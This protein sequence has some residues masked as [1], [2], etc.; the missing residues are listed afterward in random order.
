MS[1]G[2]GN[3]QGSFPWHSDS[4]PSWPLRTHSPSAH[5]LALGPLYPLAHPALTDPSQIQI[6][7]YRATASLAHLSELSDLFLQSPIGTNVR[8]ASAHS[9]GQHLFCRIPRGHPGH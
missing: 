2:L 1:E 4:A 6:Q 7:I 8:V 9:S 5:T 3:G